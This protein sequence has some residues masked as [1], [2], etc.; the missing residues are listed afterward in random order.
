MLK[1]QPDEISLRALDHR[2][3]WCRSGIGSIAGLEALEERHKSSSTSR[4]I[5]IVL[6]EILGRVVGCKFGVASFD[7]FF[8]TS[9]E[10][11]RRFLLL[12]ESWGRLV[13][14]WGDVAVVEIDRM[15]RK[16]QRKAMEE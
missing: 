4:D 16:R 6:D 7:D 12:W 1:D 5:G 8:S 13:S 9:R 10:R 2:S 3:I 14:C 11:R 15:Q